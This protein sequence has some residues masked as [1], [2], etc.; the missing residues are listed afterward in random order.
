LLQDK[1]E[2]LTDVCKI[3]STQ[4]GTELAEVSDGTLLLLGDGTAPAPSEAIACLSC[5]S[6]PSPSSL[7][8]VL[9]LWTP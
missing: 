4:L 8:W 3:I 2:V 5:R 7:T 6:S 1:A 9:T